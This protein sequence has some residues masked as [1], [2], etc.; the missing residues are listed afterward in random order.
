MHMTIG[1]SNFN[2][3]LRSVFEKTKRSIGFRKWLVWFVVHN[4]S[5]AEFFTL[6][7]ARELLAVQL[8]SF[9]SAVQLSTGQINEEI[10][11]IKDEVGDIKASVQ[12]CWH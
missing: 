11:C 6:S 7:T 5:K 1:L 4:S 9:R 10:K 8:E 12:Y 2:F 3:I